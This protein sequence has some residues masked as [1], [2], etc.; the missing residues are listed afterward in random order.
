MGQNYMFGHNKTLEI[1]IE[2]K[3]YEV[4]RL[5]QNSFYVVSRPG[6]NSFYEVS[7]LGWNSLYV[8]FGKTYFRD[9]NIDARIFDI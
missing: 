6:W 8:H 4:F 1:T 3:I 5:G 7:W 9:L 2:C